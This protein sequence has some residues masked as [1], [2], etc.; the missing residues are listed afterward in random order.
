[1]EPQ[2]KSIK[3]GR[4]S[5]KEPEG[6]KDHRI[7]NCSLGFTADKSQNIS[8]RGKRASFW[9]WQMWVRHCGIQIWL[10]RG[11]T[12]FPTSQPLTNITYPSPSLTRA[13]P[14]LAST[15]SYQDHAFLWGWAGEGWGAK[16]LYAGASWL[17]VLTLAQP[18]TCFCE[19]AQLLKPLQALVC[20]SWKVGAMEQLI[21]M[22]HSADIYWATAMCQALS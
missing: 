17:E 1:M 12:I 20:S 3:E 9:Q 21:F 6:L 15:T 18:L 14:T 13:S 2:Q 22:I 11:K 4:A 10:T 7:I 8:G 16:A 19:M 5:A